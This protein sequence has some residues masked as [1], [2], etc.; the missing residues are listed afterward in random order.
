MAES[1]V[2]A[3]MGADCKQIEDVSSQFYYASFGGVSR[4]IAFLMAGFYQSSLVILM[5]MLLR[6]VLITVVMKVFGKNSV[7][8]KSNTVDIPLSR[9]V[10]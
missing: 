9:P 5:M 3:W 6:F 2:I 7:I 1:S 4:V 8:Y 10:A